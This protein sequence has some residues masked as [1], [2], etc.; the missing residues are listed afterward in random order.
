MMTEAPLNPKSHR[1]RMTR[2]MFEKFNVPCFYISQSAVSSLYASG[3][4][5]GVVIDAGDA[6]THTVPIFEGFAIPSAI[7]RFN[8]AGQ[9]VTQYLQELLKLKQFYFQTPTELDALKDIKEKMCY[10]VP[11]YEQAIK[12]SEISQAHIKSYDLPDGRKI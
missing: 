4:T 11:N 8:L 10:V 9:N 12:E 6:V 5:T 7:Q 3:K 1:E 2:I